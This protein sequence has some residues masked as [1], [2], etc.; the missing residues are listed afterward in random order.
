MSE[1][2]IA[3]LTASLLFLLALSLAAASCRG[4]L[5]EVFKPPKVR[6]VNVALASAPVVNPKGPVAF[7]MTLSV[8]N[9]N[10]YPLNVTRV[11]YTAI[12][13]GETVAEGEERS[14]LR[15][16]AAGATCVTIPLS[17]RPE[18]FLKAGRQVLRAQRI[19]YE[20]HGS[21]SVDAPVVGTVRIPFSR[22]GSVDPVDLLIRKGFGLD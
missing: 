5:K 2:R 10:A 21:V 14:D 4:L 12:L 17:F 19:D 18:A 16:E 7:R 15:I 9:P 1:M 13:G 8:D 3:K 20:F 22:T 6:V 11:A